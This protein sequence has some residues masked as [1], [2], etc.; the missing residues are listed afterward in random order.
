MKFLDEAKIFLRSGKGGNGCVSFR[1]EKFVEFGGP[2]GGDGGNGG[3][4][5][6]KGVSNKNTLIDFRFKQHFKAQ[7]GKDGAGKKKKGANGDTILIEV[8]FGT[9]VYN[10]DYSVKLLEIFE[11][12]SQ[13]LLLKGGK[14][15]F[16]NHKFKSSRN[17]TPKKANVGYPGEEMWV[18]LR[19][20]LI[21]DVGIIGLPNAGKSSFLKSATNANPKV[22]EYPFTTLFP[23]LG[24]VNYKNYQEIVIA[25][26]PGIIKDASKGTGL[27]LK[28]LGH[29]E[30][31]YF[32][33]HFLD[34]S[35]K[36][37]F[38]NYDIIRNELKKYGKGLDKKE[39]II[40]LTK[41]DLSTK[42]IIN[43]KINTLK[44]YTKKNIYII[45]IKDKKSIAYLLDALLV[46]RTESNTTKENKWKP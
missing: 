17:I 28:F 5:I 15:G 3:D 44:N 4:I 24:V 13:V 36:N 10:D 11:E 45:S 12:N 32:L 16:G 18:R 41:R 8:P 43:D 29:I 37:I 35:K 2:D 19:L 46:A 14:G 22:A 39:E 25:D 33:L 34:I 9:S 26:I 21:A 38:K 7:N 23:N 42:K 1:R 20:N 40:V 30:K 6:F 27:G 31:C